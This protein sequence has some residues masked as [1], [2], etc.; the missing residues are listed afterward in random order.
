[1]EEQVRLC[2]KAVEAVLNLPVWIVRRMIILNKNQISYARQSLSCGA[3]ELSVSLNELSQSIK[4]I[5]RV[6][7]RDNYQ[8]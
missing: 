2:H 5:A 7:E 6:Q 1:M 3:L 4:F 8:I